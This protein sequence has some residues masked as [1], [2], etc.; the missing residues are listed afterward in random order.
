MVCNTIRTDQETIPNSSIPSS[1]QT[2]HPLSMGIL[3]P[4]FAKFYSV[5]RCKLLYVHPTTLANLSEYNIDTKRRQG[6]GHVDMA[7]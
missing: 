3:S 2:M 5:F 4:Y 7:N 6:H 1:R